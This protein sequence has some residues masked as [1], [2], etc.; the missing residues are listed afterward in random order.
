MKFNK[1]FLLACLSV[2][3]SSSALPMKR[4]FS[5]FSFKSEKQPDAKEKLKQAISKIEKT[6]E[7]LQQKIKAHEAT[8]GL[9]TSTIQQRQAAKIEASAIETKKKCLNMLQ[10]Q[11]SNLQR[12]L[13]LIDRSQSHKRRKT[14]DDDDNNV[15]SI[16]DYLNTTQEA[17]EDQ[18]EVDAI[19]EQYTK[20]DDAHIE[21]ELDRK[22]AMYQDMARLDSLYALCHQQ[23]QPSTSSAPSVPV[24]SSHDQA[25]AD[26][27]NYFD[28]SNT[29]ASSNTSTTNTIVSDSK[30]IDDEADKII[31]NL[32]KFIAEIDKDSD[33]R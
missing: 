32:R 22:Q 11:R 7:P 18:A 15:Q 8:V 2:S 3:I 26:L 1:T 14:K 4:F 25:L 17:L 28:F 33:K 19:V 12:H 10:R 29:T 13:N 16:D 24:V 5:F 20:H 6:I 30:N 21:V 9:S 27:R 31:A 23:D